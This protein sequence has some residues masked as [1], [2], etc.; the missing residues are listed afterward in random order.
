[1]T[2]QAQRAVHEQAAPLRLQ[3]A[4]DFLEQN[5]YVPH[6]RRFNELLSN[7]QSSSPSGSDALLAQISKIL[8]RKSLL[9]EAALEAL[10]IPD[11]QMIQSGTHN[12]ISLH[13]GALA[14]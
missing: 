10:T 5:R 2:T 6:V 4:G 12:H 7:V 8:V 13:L 9:G 3:K 1:M 11:L 14:Q